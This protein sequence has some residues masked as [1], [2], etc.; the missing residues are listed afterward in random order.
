MNIWTFSDLHLPDDR[1]DITSVLPL[2]PDADVCIVAGDM[3]EGRPDDAV[4]WLD[5]FI[6][7]VMPVLYVLGNHEFYHYGRD[8]VANR[9]LAQR[10]AAR[11]E[12]R[13][14]VLDDAGV[15]IDGTRFLG[16]TLWYDLEIFGSDDESMAHA[17]AGADRLTDSRFLYD[18]VKRWTPGH[19]RRWHLQSRAWLEVELQASAGPTVVVTH[20]APHRGSIAERFARDYVTAGFCSDLSDMIERHRPALWIHGHMHDS[21]DYRVG[22]TRIVC[23]PNG[24]GRENE[25]GF[26]AGMVIEID[27]D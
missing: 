19:A 8:M 22:D 23:N 6:A 20:H 25:G 11:T 12:G 13:V 2:I 16:S 27:G 9:E 10:A 1:V 14:H 5:A 24:Y 7:P 17:W 15:D 3:I 18:G 26:D 4:R 21:F